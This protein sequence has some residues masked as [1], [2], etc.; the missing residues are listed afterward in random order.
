MGGTYEKG[1]VFAAPSPVKELVFVCLWWIDGAVLS[2]IVGKVSVNYAFDE[3]THRSPIGFRKVLDLGILGIV[4][5]KPRHLF[6]RR[7]N[8]HTFLVKTKSL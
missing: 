3:I 6:L 4:E 1:R 7:H 5:P 8:Q 2:L